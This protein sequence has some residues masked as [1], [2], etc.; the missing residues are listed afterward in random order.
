MALSLVQRLMNVDGSEILAVR[1]NSTV[2]LN[3]ELIK[4]QF[5]VNVR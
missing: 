2:E 3:A 5:E 4:V 1:N